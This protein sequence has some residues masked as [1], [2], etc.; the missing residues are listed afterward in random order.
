MRVCTGC[1]S[2][3]IAAV[4]DSVREE[5]IISQFDVIQDMIRHFVRN[6]MIWQHWT[7]YKQDDVTC[8][9]SNETM[10]LLHSKYPG[11]MLLKEGTTDHSNHAIYH[12]FLR[13]PERKDL[14]Q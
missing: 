9:S 11:L 7:I 2:K 5:L 1:S 4:S 3:N 13:V 10:V 14:F 8:Y 12:R 6:W